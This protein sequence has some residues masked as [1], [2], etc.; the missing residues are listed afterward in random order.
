MGTKM[1]YKQQFRIIKKTAIGSRSLSRLAVNINRNAVIPDI[2]SNDHESI[3]I[4]I[5]TVAFLRRMILSS[6]DNPV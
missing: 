1:K 6:F 3:V 4:W 5:L 2:A